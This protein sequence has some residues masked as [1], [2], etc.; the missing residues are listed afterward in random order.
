MAN[1][2][3]FMKCLFR[4]CRAALAAVRVLPLAAEAGLAGEPAKRSG[5]L[6]AFFSGRRVVV[7][8]RY[9]DVSMRF[10]PDGSQAGFAPM[11]KLL[12]EPSAGRGRWW[13]SRERICVQ[14]RNW[15]HGEGHCFAVEMIDAAQ[16]RWRGDNGEAEIA[17]LEDAEASGR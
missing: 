14:L 9:G 15:V 17:R 6:A 10:F 3:Y 12:G 4:V 7:S 11:A 16:L 13:M 8:T 5:T 1:G 2:R